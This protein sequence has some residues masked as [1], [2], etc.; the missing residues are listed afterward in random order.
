MHRKRLGQTALLAALLAL[1]AAGT[2]GADDFAIDTKITWSDQGDVTTG[3]ACVYQST[4]CTPY[5]TKDCYDADGNSRP[6]CNYVG[7]G[8]GATTNAGVK[9]YCCI[10]YGYCVNPTPPAVATDLKCANPFKCAVVILFKDTRTDVSGDK[11]I[12]TCMNATCLRE[13]F[14]NGVSV[15][16]PGARSIT[17]GDDYAPPPPS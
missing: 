15:C 4:N 11:V 14:L 8:D 5:N 17:W 3:K 6:K 16:E 2:G 1:C 7:I 10:Q 12:K 9:L 13:I